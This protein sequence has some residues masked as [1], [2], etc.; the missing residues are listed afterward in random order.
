MRLK[1][2]KG[3][4]EKIENSKYVIT[5]NNYQTSKIFSNQNPVY[6]DRKG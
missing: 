5:E 1:N 3:A 2:V 6:I 4:Y